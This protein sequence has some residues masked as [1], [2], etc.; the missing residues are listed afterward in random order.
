MKL[1]TLDNLELE[2]KTVILRCDLN[3]PLD[4]NGKVTDITKIKNIYKKTFIV[5]IVKLFC[6]F[7]KVNKKQ[8]INAN[9]GI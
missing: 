9:K 8:L 1:K 7:E 6:T 5:L 4:S 2:G 3:V